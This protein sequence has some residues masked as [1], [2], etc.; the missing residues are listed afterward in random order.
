MSGDDQSSED[1]QGSSSNQPSESGSL[2]RDGR[3]IRRLGMSEQERRDRLERKRRFRYRRVSEDEDKKDEKAKEGPKDVG[4]ST[5]QE[6]TV[7]QGIRE[8]EPTLTETENAQEQKPWETVV[9]GSLGE[10]LSRIERKN[11]EIAQQRY[12]VKHH[13]ENSPH[14]VPHNQKVLE[15]LIQERE[16]REKNNRIG[17]RLE[18][19]NWALDT[20]QC[21]A[22][23]INIRAAI[24][25]YQSGEIGYSNNFT[26][27][28]AGHIV[29]I[30]PTY[31]SFC[32]DREDRLDRYFEAFGPGWLWQEPPLAGSGFGPIAMKGLC[33]DRRANETNYHIGCYP[34][35]QRYTVDRKLVMRATATDRKAKNTEVSTYFKTLMDSGATF[36]SL[37]SHDLKR[38]KVDF[39]YYSAQGV[40]GIQTVSNYVKYRFIEMYVSPCSENGETLVGDG[41]HAVWPNEP[42]HVGMFAPVWINE[43]PK[44]SV[45]FIHRLSGMVPFDVCYMSSAPTMRK[46]WLGEDR[47]DVLG[48]K[49]MPAHLR[50]D[51]TKVLQLTS[52]QRIEELRNGAKTPDQVIF[53]HDICAKGNKKQLL[54]D[55]D[56]RGVRGKSEIAIIEHELNEQRRC[57]APKV[58]DRVVL[59]PRQNTYELTP[60]DARVWQDDFL[61]EK[62][63]LRAASEETAGRAEARGEPKKKKRKS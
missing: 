27:I 47:R 34:V 29:D 31:R 9:I 53:L 32:E 4:P 44:E 11:R 57:V 22:E 6:E 1:P 13:E 2:R 56:W 41:D 37:V 28:Y 40:I 60:F 30:C 8:Y 61:S 52:H 49:R 15:E 21:E 63:I 59:E 55:G 43:I 35:N 12:I 26:L 25:G 18:L 36:P 45:G 46:F 42:R 20:C 10:N 23:E 50:Y 7:E 51:S 14:Q 62:Q 58:T 16:Q 38:L 48:T 3:V 24:E 19:L 39:R 17:E 5:S 54:S 33:L